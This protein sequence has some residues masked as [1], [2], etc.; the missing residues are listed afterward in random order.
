MAKE[1]YYERGVQWSLHFTKLDLLV[2]VTNVM[3][4]PGG[5]LGYIVPTGM[6]FYPVF[7]DGSSNADLTAGTCIFKVTA[8]NT[9]ISNGPEPV[10]A[11]LVQRAVA[12][13]GFGQAQ[14]ITAGQVIAAH[15][16]CDASFAPNNSADA[17]LF[18]FGY[19]VPDPTA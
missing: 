7:G 19:L 8:N 16:I 5:G 10:L 6:A 11:D 18:V 9:A 4:R 12:V 2:N 13:K 15:A 14:K 17:D 1:L 3:T